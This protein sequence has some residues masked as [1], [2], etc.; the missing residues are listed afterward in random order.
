M[1]GDESKIALEPDAIGVREPLAASQTLYYDYTF[2]TWDFKLDALLLE[3]KG[4]I[5]VLSEIRYKDVHGIER[6]VTTC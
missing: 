4:G 3:E 5:Y 2:Q 1:A 6:R